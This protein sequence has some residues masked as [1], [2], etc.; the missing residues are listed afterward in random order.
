MS[1]PEKFAG[2]SPYFFPGCRAIILSACYSTLTG[3]AQKQAFFENMIKKKTF[4][5]WV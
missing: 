2:A 5:D 3:I 4:P 1:M